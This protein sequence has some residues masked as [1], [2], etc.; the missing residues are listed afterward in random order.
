M[1]FATF[2]LKKDE[3]SHQVV[4][5]KLSLKRWKL[6]DIHVKSFKKCEHQLLACKNL[7]II[8]SDIYYCRVDILLRTFI[9]AGGENFKN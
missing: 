2:K 3:F 1:N 9:R 6:I 8:C 7:R 5:T 4:L